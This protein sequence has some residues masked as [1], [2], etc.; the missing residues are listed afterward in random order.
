M[1]KISYILFLICLLSSIFHVAKVNAEEGSV[2]DKLLD[3]DEVKNNHKNFY[4]RNY[5]NLFGFDLILDD[6]LKVYL[7]DF[8]KNNILSWPFAYFFV[9]VPR[10]SLLFQV[11]QF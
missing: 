11:I 8:V 10:P 3:G 2:Y 5:H 1:K 9:D 4:H 6:E 7:L